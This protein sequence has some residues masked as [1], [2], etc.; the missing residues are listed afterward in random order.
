[1][2][3]FNQILILILFLDKP[4][5]GGILPASNRP[6][7]IYTHEHIKEESSHS[8]SSTVQ[9]G[10]HTTT[11]QIPTTDKYSIPSATLSAKPEQ[12]IPS[13]VLATQ[14]QNQVPSATL[15]TQP[16]TSAKNPLSIL[17]K[18]S[19]QADR[20]KADATKPEIIPQK[21]QE[22]PSI[23]HIDSTV[24]N[25]TLSVQPPKTKEIPSSSMAQIEPSVPTETLA[26]QQPTSVKNPLSILTKFSILA[27]R[28]KADGKKPEPISSITTINIE[29]EPAKE[30]KIEREQP[31]NIPITKPVVVEENIV[32]S[33]TIISSI[34]E[35]NH[36]NQQEI[37]TPPKVDREPT[38]FTGNLIKKNDSNSIENWL[39]FAETEL[40]SYQTDDEFLKILPEFMREHV[41]IYIFN[42]FLLNCRENFLI[43]IRLKR[44]KD[45]N[46]IGNHLISKIERKSNAEIQGMHDNCY[47][48]RLND[49][50]CDDKTHEFIISCFNYL[51]NNEKVEIIKVYV[52]E[53]ALIVN[54]SI[55]I[56]QNV[57]TNSKGKMN[58]FSQS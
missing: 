45:A 36:V 2:K 29:K 32:V 53:P 18:L 9:Y 41:K 30:I 14:P 43:G 48:V 56:S 57:V 42:K 25:A 55:L 47:I 21:H 7:V 3:Q 22:T 6:N 26:T 34:Q 46:E 33:Q 40:K 54:N 5:R 4:V 10:H 51:I 17:T 35:T 37:I 23:I 12:T 8:Y 52:Y 50:F 1:M 31:T 58:K 44:K 24:P 19:L 15:A 20:E 13:A 28:E 38:D 49:I 16:P 39:N 27:D 11:Q